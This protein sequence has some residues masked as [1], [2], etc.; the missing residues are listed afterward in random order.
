MTAV[1]G[2]LQGLTKD[3]TW[4]DDGIDRM[5]RR[6]TVA[7]I[8]IELLVVYGGGFLRGNYIQCFT[9]KYFTGAQEKYS[10]QLCWLESTHY[11]LEPQNGDAV[12]DI[13]SLGFYN[14]PIYKTTGGVSGYVGPYNPGQRVAVSYYQWVPVFMI[15]M[16]LL[17]YVPFLVWKHIALKSGLPLKSMVT[18]ARSM[19]SVNEKGEAMRSGYCQDMT[20]ILLRYSEARR[21][22]SKSFIGIGKKEGNLIYYSYLMIKLLYI[23]MFAIQLL[24]LQ[25]FLGNDPRVNILSHGVW[26]IGQIIN[27][28]TWPQHPAFPID[29]TC[30]IMAEQQGN[31]LP[32]T[33]QCILPMNLYFD[34]FF[35]LFTIAFPILMAMF[36]CSTLG[37]ILS[38]TQGGRNKF[39]HTHLVRPQAIDDDDDNNNSDASDK[40]LLEAFHKELLLKDGMFA[41]KLIKMNVGGFVCD[42]VLESLWQRFSTSRRERESPAAVVPNDYQL[43]DTLKKRASAPFHNTDLG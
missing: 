17:S 35:A 25:M 39:L 28:A 32:Y 20:D 40:K 14:V 13:G 22:A 15:I 26:V 36:F 2:L 11:I 37:W 43:P 6:Y 12:E 3:D 30:I 19:S 9:P 24:L 42:A 29:T 23:I 33:L 10:E 1:V 4:I 41:L 16:A 34:K 21:A 18:A 8:A 38:M 31:P 27:T 5:T 7:L